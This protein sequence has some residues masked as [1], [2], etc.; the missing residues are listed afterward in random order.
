MV[1][2]PST[3]ETVTVSLK[4]P[5]GL[6]LRLHAMVDTQEAVMGGGIRIVKTARVVGRSYTIKGYSTPNS[7]VPMPALASAFMMTPGIPK[8]F[9]DEWVKQNH[10]HPFVEAGLIFASPSANYAAGKEREMEAMKCGLEPLDP[11]H[12]PIKGV[13]TYDTKAA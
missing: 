7:T 13:Q 1:S 4:H 6:I 5:H 3:N 2:A 10:D 9:W 12:L 8:E 11:A